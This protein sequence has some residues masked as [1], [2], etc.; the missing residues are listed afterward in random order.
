MHGFVFAPHETKVK[1]FTD[2]EAAELIRL[3]FEQ[4]YGI[5]DAVPQP[6][7]Q[8]ILTTFDVDHP[9]PDAMA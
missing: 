5:H 2:E 9:S 1:D 8:R 7:A 3:K 6:F 4:R